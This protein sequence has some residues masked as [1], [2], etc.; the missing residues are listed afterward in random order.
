[1]GTLRKLKNMMKKD[2]ELHE[3]MIRSGRHEILL[4]LDGDKVPDIGLLDTERNGDVDAIAVDL[5]GNGEFNFYLVDHD[6]NG[7]PD[8]ISFYQDGDDIPIKA[9]FGRSVESR[10]LERIS[11]IYALMSAADF[12]ARDIMDAL[13]DLEDFIDE[14]Y[15]RYKEEN[16]TKPDVED[17]Q[18]SAE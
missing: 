12:A 13:K 7:I 15:A 18:E 5:T 2:E 1:M 14:E 17:A 10:M 8:E 11:K 16:P 4:D 6:G 3:L 9:V